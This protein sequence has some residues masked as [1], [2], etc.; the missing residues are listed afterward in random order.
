MDMIEKPKNKRRIAR[1]RTRELAINSAR[2]LWSEPGSYIKNGI[3]DVSNHM[4]RSVGSL[5]NVFDSKDD[6]WRAAFGTE[7]PT[8]S[9]H[10]REALA[11]YARFLELDEVKERKKE[12][13]K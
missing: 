2:A 11:M 9:V 8:D 10:T 6:L 7:P 13:V 3:R 4:G 5:F 1:E 12:E